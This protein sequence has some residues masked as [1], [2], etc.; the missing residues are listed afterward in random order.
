VEK[1]SLKDLFNY[2]SNMSDQKAI[3][4]IRKFTFISEKQLKDLLDL[5]NPKSLRILQRILLE[6]FFFL[7]HGE[8]G[9]I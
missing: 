9:L 3:D 8:K 7:I 6:L 1:T 2:F 5:N 4:Y